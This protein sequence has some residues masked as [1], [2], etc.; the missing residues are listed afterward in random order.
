MYTIVSKRSKNKY[1]NKVMNKKTLKTR[2][3]IIHNNISI[4]YFWLFQNRP[5]RIK[6]KISERFSNISFSKD[7]ETGDKVLNSKYCGFVDLF[8]IQI[9][10]IKYIIKQDYNIYLFNNEYII[11]NKK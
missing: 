1:Q 9:H 8:H 2:T 11:S 10:W 7:S 4:D 5:S 6:Q 3:E